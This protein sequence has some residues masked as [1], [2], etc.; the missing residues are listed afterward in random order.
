MFFL[1]HQHRTVSR[2]DQSKNKSKNSKE[3]TRF[4]CLPSAMHSMNSSHRAS[5]DLPS[6]M[7]LRENHIVCFHRFHFAWP[8]LFRYFFFVF[9]SVRY[10][11]SVGQGQIQIIICQSFGLR[12]FVFIQP[13]DTKGNCFQLNSTRLFRSISIVPYRFVSME[14]IFH[15]NYDK[16]SITNVHFILMSLLKMHFHSKVNETFT[17]SS[18]FNFIL[19]FLAFKRCVTSFLSRERE[20]DEHQ[21]GHNNWNIIDHG[22]RLLL[23]FHWEFSHWVFLLF[24]SLLVSNNN[25]HWLC[26]WWNQRI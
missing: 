5:G 18:M 16:C 25:D 26:L 20:N 10:Q 8:F 14:F 4:V 15:L 23:C 13:T 7:S 19:L 6:P 2:L 12:T 22:V 9:T 17:N 24:F 21:N 1:F 3:K 11:W